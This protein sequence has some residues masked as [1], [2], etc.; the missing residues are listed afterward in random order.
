[1]NYYPLKE[2]GF[3]KRYVITE[4]GEIINLETSKPI[5]PNAK[6]QYRLVN[7]KGESEYINL[8]KL[9]RQVYNREYSKDDIKSFKGE[10]WKEIDKQGKYYI[11]SC[12]RVKSYQGLNAIILKPSQNTKGYLR[13]YLSVETN[14][15]QAFF[16]HRLVAFGFIPNE[17]L[18]KDTVDH[19]DF[20][21]QNNNVDNL[22]WLTRSENSKRRRERELKNA[23]SSKLENNNN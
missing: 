5:K 19:I 3:D 18:S 1:M 20:N 14:D 6:N 21:I 10:I 16:I 2:L 7:N 12:G 4:Q 9:Y 13:V 23:E 15:K 22:R 11:S 8:K 17:D